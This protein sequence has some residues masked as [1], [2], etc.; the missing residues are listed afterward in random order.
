MAS[1]DK[2]SDKRSFFVPPLFKDSPVYGYMY[3]IEKVQLLTLEEKILINRI[4]IGCS[5]LILT[6]YFKDVKKTAK[7]RSK[8]SKKALVST[9]SI[10]DL[11]MKVKDRSKFRPSNIRKK[12]PD[13]NKDIQSADLSDILKSLSDMNLITKTQKDARK[14]GSPSKD[15]EYEAGER[16]IHSFYQSTEYF[17]SLKQVISKP[18]V[19][20]L[21]FS[22]LLESKLIY[23]W[24]DHVCLLTFYMLKFG[25]KDTSRKIDMATGITHNRLKNEKLY[26]KVTYLDD[27]RLKEFADKTAVSVLQH[28]EEY[29]EMFTNLYIM[30]GICFNG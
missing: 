25:N 14:R 9:Y 26:D 27:K 13:E 22:F 1:P 4:L 11:I 21:I 19:R 2:N 16:G 7:T 17:V 5:K 29:E 10:I 28:F 24:L 3:A 20:M 8:P 23:R 18:V 6:S 15:S 30:G 12:L